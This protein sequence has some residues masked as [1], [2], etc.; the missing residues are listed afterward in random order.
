MTKIRKREEV[1]DQIFFAISNPT[2]R[3]ILEILFDGDLYA[4]E[5]GEKFSSSL[6][7]V[8]NHLKFLTECKLVSK[9]RESQKI[10][11][12]LLLD[13]FKE[14]Q[15]WLE[16]LGKVNLIDYDNLENFLSNLEKE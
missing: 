6:P 3:K 8:S 1:L 12:S 7:T 2:R 9:K 5:I 15:V 13:N 4:G 11:Y 14:I 16:T 10:K